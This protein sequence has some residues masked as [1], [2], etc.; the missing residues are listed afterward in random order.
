MNGVRAELEL[1]LESRGHGGAGAAR[2]VEEA[3]LAL[4]IEGLLERPVHTLSGGELQRVALAAALVAG[5]RL[6]LLDEPTSQ[7]DP[8]AGEELLSQLRRLNE[9]WGTTV[10]L[11]EHRLER[12]LA[13]ADRVIALDRG[14]IA[15]DSSPG[16]FLEWA[17]RA[18]ARAAYR[19]R[20]ACS[21]SPA[22]GRCPVTV[23]D[24]RAP[25]C[26]DVVRGRASTARAAAA[27]PQ[28]RPPSPLSDVWVEFDDGTGAGAVALRGLSL[29]VAP[30]ETVA[31]LG[32]N[33]AGKSTLLRA[34]AG[35]ARARP[36]DA[37]APTARWRCCCRRRPT[38][39]CTSA[40]STS[41]RAAAAAAALRELGLEDAGERDPRDLVRRRAPA[42]GARHRARG[43]R[44]RRRRPARGGRARRADARH[45]PGAQAR[46]RRAPRASRRRGRRGARRDPRHRVRGARLAP[47][48]AARQGPRRRRRLDRARCC[49]AAATSRPRSRACSGPKARVVLRGG[50]RGRCSRRRARHSARD[51]GARMSWQ[52]RQR[53]DR[54]AGRRRGH[55][56]VRE[57]P[58]ER[59]A[60][61]A[62]R[63]AGRARRRGARAVRG[64]A[65]RAGHDRRRAAVGLRARARARLHGRRA[66][67]AR[68][69]PVPRPG[70]VDAL[71]DGRVGRGRARRRAARIA[72]RAGGSAAGR[73]RSAVRLAG[74]AFGAWMDL[75]TLT[76]F[77]ARHLGRRLRRDRRRCRCR[78][79]SRTR[80]GTSRCAW[81]SGPAFVR[82]LERFSRRLHV[83][84]APLDAAPEP[85]RGDDHDHARADA[86]AGR[87]RDRERRSALGARRACATSSARRTTDGG[88]GGAPRQASSQLVTGWTVLGLEA[89]GRHPLDVRSGG[90]HADRL[91]PRGRPARWRRPASWSARSSRCAA[92]ASIRGASA[93]ATCSPTSSASGGR[94]GRSPG[95]RTGRRS[96]SCR[97]ARAGARPRVAGGAPR[98][99][100][101]RAPAE[102][103]T[104][105]SRMR[106]AAAAA[107]W[108]RPAP[109][110]RAWPPR[111]GAGPAW[112]TRALAYLRK[113]P[114]PRRRIRPDPRATARTRSRPRGRC[115]ASSRRAA[116]R[117]RSAARAAR[118]CAYLATLQQGDGS[119]R[120]SRS[121][122]QTP[123]WVTAQVVAA[124]RRKPFPVQEPQRRRVQKTP[125]PAPASRS[126]KAKVVKEEA[127]APR[128]TGR[129][130][131]SRRAAPSPVAA[132]ARSATHDTAAPEHDSRSIAL[133]VGAAAALA[134]AAPTSAPTFLRPKRQR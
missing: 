48:R 13:A 106:P 43:A 70:A 86:R 118:R 6:L 99:R 9:E 30:G 21:R 92:P 115:R 120:Y 50:G 61:R 11:G 81:R 39:S 73:W 121:S 78:S 95:C 128:A 25:R 79:T 96:G 57:P 34:A 89:A 20:R 102:R 64:R 53:A 52:A 105:A 125:E 126:T 63:R 15:C 94:T 33:G 44:D 133:P 38:T 131:P 62:G 10:L 113:A 19:P 98:G 29:D 12:C 93:G 114:E 32:R 134:L 97:C 60:G 107:S 90:A 42:P 111:A 1:S 71:A 51:G 77:A 26:R 28:R 117:P 75:F 27:T 23:K 129:P 101:A 55:P 46:A 40:S 88:F 35:R 84:W 14:A 87:L 112:S 110:C 56:L 58:P 103:A 47:L 37:C 68:L 91:H 41:C 76:S 72:S 109:R 80:S 108:T 24:A 104:A 3:A 59:E 83:R 82:V 85:R 122:A 124:L 31:L 74:L 49:R 54:L 7:L 123:V 127:H 100:L 116:R 69:E 16:A 119:F 36:R 45:G 4:G 66:R 5:P 130:S 18:P 17:A 67:R 132:R 22:S 2:A 8:V 65:E